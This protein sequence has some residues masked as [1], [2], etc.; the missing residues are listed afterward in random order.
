M[1]VSASFTVPPQPVFPH[2]RQWITGRL[3]FSSS[4]FR[5]SAKPSA[6]SVRTDAT[7]RRSS[8][9]QSCIPDLNQRVCAP[10]GRHPRR[11]PGWTPTPGS[12]PAAG[13]VDVLQRAESWELLL[14]LRSQVAGRPRRGYP[15][16]SAGCGRKHD[17]SA[18]SAER[19]ICASSCPI[20][21]RACAF[22]VLL[23]RLVGERVHRADDP[24]DPGIWNR[25]TRQP[26]RNSSGVSSDS[27]ITLSSSNGSP[28]SC[29][30]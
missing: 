7:M 12:C 9:S 20:H 25:V 19:R 26:F 8:R 22:R 14:E 29:R 11:E 21:S 5:S 23:R 28:K 2:S 13:P 30:A 18:H 4:G 3:R 1:R 10:V 15:G 27:P 16:S 24:R 17:A 6:G